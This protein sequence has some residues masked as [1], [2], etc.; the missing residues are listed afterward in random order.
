MQSKLQHNQLKEQGGRVL[1]LHPGWI[2]NYMQGKLDEAADLTP[3]QAAKQV[4]Q[5]LS[6]YETTN[7]SGAHFLNYLGNELRW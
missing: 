3:E 1:S 5:V 2:Q 6:N 7:K 4:I